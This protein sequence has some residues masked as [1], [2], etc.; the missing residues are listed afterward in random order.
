MKF[1]NI[2]FTII[3]IAVLVVSAARPLPSTSADYYPTGQVGNFG[4][5]SITRGSNHKGELGLL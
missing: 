2:F 3:A 1:I 5:S 4:G